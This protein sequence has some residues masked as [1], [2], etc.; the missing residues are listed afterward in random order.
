MKDRKWENGIGVVDS[1]GLQRLFPG[2]SLLGF[3][4]FR[5]GSSY[6][7][8]GGMLKCGCFVALCWIFLAKQGTRQ[9]YD[10]AKSEEQSDQHA[11]ADTNALALNLRAKESGSDPDGEIHSRVLP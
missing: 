7:E 11:K 4:P 1:E 3:A 10:A 2:F 5:F 9:H 6:G 8:I